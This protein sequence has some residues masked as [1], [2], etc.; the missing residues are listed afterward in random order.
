MAERRRYSLQIDHE[1]A[2]LAIAR[3]RVYVTYLFLA[4]DGPSRDE[5]DALDEYELR[6]VALERGPDA[7]HPKFAARALELLDQ[8]DEHLGR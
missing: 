2:D 8:A 6:E 4:G 5:I 3:A 1:A 7:P